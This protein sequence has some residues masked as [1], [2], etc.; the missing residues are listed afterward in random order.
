MKEYHIQK[1]D[2]GQR[3]DKYLKR[4]LPLAS[5]GFLYKMLRKKNIVLNDK[6]A[7]GNELLVQGDSL[8]V[9]FME[10]TLKKFE[11]TNT[12]T[13]S[14]KQEEVLLLNAHRS[15]SGIS[16]LYENTHLL[17]LYKPASILTQKAMPGD[18][19]VNE[20]FL[21]YLLESKQRTVRDFTAF[22]P[23]VLNR[24]DRNTS[25]IVICGKTL[26]G[27]RI[28]SQMLK[29]RSLQK[30]YRTIVLGQMTE[31]RTITAYLSKDAQKNQVTILSTPPA[32]TLAQYDKIVTGYHAIAISDA[33]S[34]LEIELITGKTHQIRAHLQSI[35]HPIIGDTKYGIGQRDTL[36]GQHHLKY[37]L[38]H[39]YRLVFP[40]MPEE[41]SDLSG[42][43]ILCPEPD[44]FVKLKAALF[45]IK[46]S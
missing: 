31:D 44:Y 10:E 19:S 15:L 40:Q 14:A 2:A 1:N 5:T 21:G 41:L 34:Y 37:Q 3:L 4:C 46:E 42:R 11:G 43:E 12:D 32:N 36:A 7:E 39:A 45:Q 13:G 30:Y 18:M 33:C 26:P 29:E 27:S 20:W 8:K 16:I 35:G 9:Y 6:K 28:V 17:F 38:L 22:R 24:L 25:G 23:S